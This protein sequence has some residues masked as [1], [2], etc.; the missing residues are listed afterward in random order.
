VEEIQVAAGAARMLIEV[1]QALERAEVEVAEGILEVR[2]YS[3]EIL[4]L[5]GCGTAPVSRSVT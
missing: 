5:L 1:W 3:P 4:D 2:N